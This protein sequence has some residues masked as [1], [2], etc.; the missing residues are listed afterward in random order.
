ML[1][2]GE[3]E[4]ATVLIFFCIN[5]EIYI[6]PSTTRLISHLLVDRRRNIDKRIVMSGSV[7]LVAHL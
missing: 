7:N 1:G 5:P 4:D 6:L 2:T 3:G